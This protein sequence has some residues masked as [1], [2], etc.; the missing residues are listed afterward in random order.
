MAEKHKEMTDQQ[1]LAKVQAVLR[2][3]TAADWRA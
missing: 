1:I 2:P 3:D